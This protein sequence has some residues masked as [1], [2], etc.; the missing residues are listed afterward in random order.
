MSQPSFEGVWRWNS[1]SQNWDLGV[2]QD[3]Q[4][5]RVRLQGSKH[6]LLGC[7]LYHWKVIKVWMSKMGLHGP[8]GHL[9]HKLWQKERPGVKL[10]IWLSTIKSRELTQ[11]QCVQ[12]EYATSLESLRGELQV[13]FRPH[14]NQRSEQKVMI[15]QSFGS[16]NW[17]SFR[18]PP[19]ESQDKKPFGCGCHREA[20]NILYGGRWW[21]SLSLGRD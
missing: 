15:S 3:S 6:L 17:D 12:G 9:K 8:F 2:L 20:H 10:A 1:H 5:F 21:L 7:S 19:W 16:P 18:I 13:F 11:P 4:N 14:P